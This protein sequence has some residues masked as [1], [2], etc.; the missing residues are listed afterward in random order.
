MNKADKHVAEMNQ[1]IK[2]EQRSKVVVSK[3]LKM[4]IKSLEDGINEQKKLLASNITAYTKK[5][6][7]LEGQ[8]GDS[9]QLIA[10]K[11][12]EMVTL[13]QQLNSTEKNLHQI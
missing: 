8:L 9:K 1:Y 2:E 3:E 10:K 11:K 4:K 7:E 12:S 6:H 13:S 5:Q